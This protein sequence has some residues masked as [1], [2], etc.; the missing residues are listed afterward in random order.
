VC[1]D[2]PE[3]CVCRREL[4]WRPPR[5][6]RRLVAWRLHRRPRAGRRRR[7]DG[8]NRGVVRRGRIS[9]RTTASGVRT[10]G[11]SC[12][13][14]V[15]RRSAS[16]FRS[17]DV[18]CAADLLRSARVCAPADELPTSAELRIGPSPDDPARGRISQRPARAPRRWREPAVAVGLGA[19]GVATSA[20]FAAA[21]ELARRSFRRP[22][23]GV[24]ITPP[25]GTERH[26]PRRTGE[27][28]PGAQRHLEGR[29]RH[30][31]LATSTAKVGVRPRTVWLVSVGGDVDCL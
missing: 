12:A 6:P 24:P 22:R 29:I 30:L 4:A 15:L 21:L 28:D 31:P 3:P 18:L 20:A 17:A 13:V 27:N 25:V 2:T 19:V 9:G 11:L 7:G 26:V 14:A 23:S 8:A 5:R 16:L 1:G 10:A